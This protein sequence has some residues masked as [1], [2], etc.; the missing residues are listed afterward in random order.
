MSN[1][2]NTTDNSNTKKKKFNSD[3]VK[4]IPTKKISEKT[5][6]NF[7]SMKGKNLPENTKNNILSKSNSQ[8]QGSMKKVAH[9]QNMEQK[10]NEEENEDLNDVRI[11]KLLVTKNN[12]RN[13]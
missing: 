8:Q 6:S 1:L 7:K 9:Q 10:N 12:N 2:D 3:F 4:S 13:K 5:I 11:Q